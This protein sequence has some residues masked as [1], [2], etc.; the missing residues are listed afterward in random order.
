MISLDK[1][2]T[3]HDIP[4]GLYF[5]KVSFAYGNKLLLD[6]FELSIPGGQVTAILGP[7]GIGKS[8]LLSLIA[9]LTKPSN[10][11]II[12]SEGTSLCGK[13]A[14]MKQTDLL[15]PW[16]S[17]QANVDLG[18]RLRGEK[19]NLLEAR[20][21]LEIVGLKNYIEAKPHELS[22]GMKQRV[23]L[24]RTL[25]ENRPIVLMDEPF[26]ALDTLTK[27][28]LQS[29]SAKLFKNRTVIFVTHDPNEALRISNQ[30]IVIKGCPI[31][32]NKPIAVPGTAPRDTSNIVL[33]KK[34]TDLLSKLKEADQ[35]V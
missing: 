17:I 1:N 25:I 13:I 6:D 34:Y 19:N 8:T 24:A 30:V 27:L 3:K 9:N 20:K 5:K 15:L 29:L 23:A 33:R 12:S 35:L 7:S 31:Q 21:M 4:I 14:F 28:R 22:V 10:G 2:N 11:K 32:V 18:S 16:L 26:S